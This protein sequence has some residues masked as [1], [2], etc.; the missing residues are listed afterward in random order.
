MSQIT[1]KSEEK[2]NRLVSLKIL[3]FMFFGGEFI[4]NFKDT[5]LQIFIKTF[6]KIHLEEINY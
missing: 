3:I 6:Q 4:E 2:P 5:M 1:D